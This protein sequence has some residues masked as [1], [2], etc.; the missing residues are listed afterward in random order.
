MNLEP[1]LISLGPCQKT[2]HND[3]EQETNKHVA[4][5]ERALSS[6]WIHFGHRKAIIASTIVISKDNTTPGLTVPPG[7]VKQTFPEVTLSFPP[8]AHYTTSHPQWELY[9][10]MTICWGTNEEL[11][12]MKEGCVALLRRFSYGAIIL[13][14]PNTQ[15]IHNFLLYYWGLQRVVGSRGRNR[16][17]APNTILPV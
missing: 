12:H 7:S 4:R 8:Y 13:W 16:K 10:Q 5:T 9:M 17:R 1:T 3:T 11:G 14:G 15:W 2:S 6:F